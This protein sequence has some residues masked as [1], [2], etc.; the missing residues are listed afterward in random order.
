MKKT[1]NEASSEGLSV[2]SVMAII[3]D[4]F[5]IDIILQIQNKCKNEETKSCLSWF[6]KRI[7]PTT[8]YELSKAIEKNGIVRKMVI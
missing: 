3:E 1:T 8:I 4:L 2:N 6:L 7:I 5:C